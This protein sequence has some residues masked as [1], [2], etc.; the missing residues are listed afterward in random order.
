MPKRPGRPQRPGQGVRGEAGLSQALRRMPERR[1]VPVPTAVGQRPAGHEPQSGHPTRAHGQVVH[2]ISRAATLRWSAQVVH[3]TSSTGPVST[4]PAPP[5]SSAS[6]RTTEPARA[7]PHRPDMSETLRQPPEIKD[8]FCHCPRWPRPAV[9]AV[10]TTE[11][12]GS[13][14]L[15]GLVFA[16]GGESRPVRAEG[17]RVD[18]IG[19]AGEGG[20]GCATGHIP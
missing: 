1:T 10:R 5:P 16:G 2:A 20:G 11:S 3:A 12:A 17:H 15:H 8:A 4:A 6:A 14:Q 7:R 13:P 19:V 9:S 18:T